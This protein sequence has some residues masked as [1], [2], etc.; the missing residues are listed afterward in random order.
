MPLAQ[1]WLAFSHF[2]HYPQA[3]W[4]LLVLILGGGDCVRSR[5]LMVS[6]RNSPVKL[7]ISPMAASTPTS[8]FNQRLWGFISPQWNP[9]L[10][11]LCNPHVVPPGLS[12]RKCGT[13]RSTSCCLIWSAR[14]RPPWASS[15]LLA[16][17]PLHPGYSFLLL[18][19]VWMNVSSLTPWL[20]DYHTVRFSVS[21]GCFLFFNLLSFFWLCEEAKCICL[22]L[23]LGRK[24]PFHFN[25]NTW[26][27]HKIKH[28][29]FSLMSSL[30]YCSLR[31]SP[32]Y[33]EEAIIIISE[34][35]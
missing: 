24:S 29:G 7:G 34:L 1:V 8:V 5:T 20:L 23:H 18:P 16:M 11:S 12:A 28:I 17:S 27:Q 4:A 21:S 35:S 33:Q 30:K 9:G 13:A 22:Y 14:W 2:S 19:P 10:H 3:N 6:P 31:T 15:R 26:A 25:P 32:V